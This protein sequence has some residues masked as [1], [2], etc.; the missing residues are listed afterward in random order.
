MQE[1]FKK[2]RSWQICNNNLKSRF[3]NAPSCVKTSFK[4]EFLAKPRDFLEPEI[5]GTGP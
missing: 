2:L 1:S 5:Q 3:T 4:P